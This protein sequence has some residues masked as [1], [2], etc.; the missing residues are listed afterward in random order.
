MKKM[1]A[2]ILVACCFFPTAVLAW[3]NWNTLSTP[4]FKVFYQPGM[5]SDAYNVLQTLEHY[6]PY[7]EK[8]TGNSVLNTAMKI[9]DIG[10]LVNG[11]ANPVGNVIGLYRYPPTSDELSYCDDWWQMVATHEYIHQL[12]LTNDNGMPRLIRQLLG[13][14]LFVQL[15]QPMWMT[16]GI[17]VYGESQLSPT[18]GR[19]NSG[20]YT[21]IISALAKEDRLPSLT[22][23]SY[24]ST[25]T[26]IAHYYVFGGSF[27]SYLA[28]TY[29]EDRF[30]MLYDD[31]SSRMES[32]A[33]AATPGLS[34]NVAFA[35]VYGKPLEQLWFDWHNYEKNKA[36]TM[37]QQRVTHDGWNKSELKI[38]GNYLY[39]I[40][41]KADKTGPSSMFYTSGLAKLDISKPKASAKMV[42]NQN[43]DFPCGYQIANDKLYYSRNE[44]KKGFANNENDGYGY[45]TQIMVS[46]LDGS[47]ARML[48]KGPIRAFFTMP[49]GSLLIAEDSDGYRSST[50]KRLDPTGKKVL[51][52]YNTN[53]LISG[54][55]ADAGRIMITA[56]D[57]WKNNSIY[58]LDTASARLIPVIDTPSM[59]T[60]TGLQGDLLSFTALYNG[61]TGSYIY[62]LKTGECQ[63]YSKFTDLRS[64]VSAPDA[65]TYFLSINGNGVDV[66]A[67]AAPLVSFSIPKQEHVT[68]PF[69]RM[70]ITPVK[71]PNPATSPVSKASLM[72]NQ[73]TW[74][75]ALAAKSIRRGT[76]AENLKHLLVPRMLRLPILEGN[77]DSL[78]IGAVLVGNDVVGDIP[79]WQVSGVYD[80]V[81]KKTQV[82]VS[83]QNSLL[84]PIHQSINFS[85]SDDGSISLNNYYNLFQSANY[86]LSSV[87]LGL[88]LG[89]SD[90]YNRRVLSPYVSNRLI[91]PTGSLQMNNSYLLEDKTNMGSTKNRKGWQSQLSIKQRSGKHAQINS[92][93][94]AAY[95]P[96]ANYDEVF[97]PIRGYKDELKS[98]SGFTVRNTIYRP[99]YKVREGIWTPQIYLEDISAGLFFDAAFR[100][101]NYKEPDHYSYGLELIAEIGAAFSGMLNAGARFGYDKDG[102]M[103]VGMILGM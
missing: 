72:S 71:T 97:Y 23:A 53:L 73:S 69:N 88:S 45:I 14:L 5:E 102:N 90:G 10:N 57:F 58:R 47:G 77:G 76:Y 75:E 13:N 56:R 61:N 84:R 96:D 66:Y 91:W 37:P 86:G 30:A 41:R 67:D 46:E 42:I 31:N 32:Y 34:L 103:F 18:A 101:D 87:S 8:L 94:N 25:D 20:Y 63:H 55:F 78:S 24:Y 44:V 62:N 60:I 36:Y 6:R 43:T 82:D 68:P 85:S 83:V 15:H 92:T 93:I 4:Y 59:E 39:Y 74:T 29:G 27:H 79:M 17:T 38:N 33:N 12:Q 40:V 9:E 19:M 11:Y 21:S 7:V 3:S 65:N 48:A 2:A 80:T 51:E 49:D 81:T 50:I 100:K 1:I 89:A 98:N 54:I 64:P 52:Q 35:R 95:D 22:K 16:E 26:P 28:K 99:I 70:E